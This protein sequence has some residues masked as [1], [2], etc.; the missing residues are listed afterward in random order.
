MAVLYVVYLLVN[1][2]FSRV[3]PGRNIVVLERRYVDRNSSIVL[4]RLMNDYYF[5]LITQGG[6]TVIKKLDEVEAGKLDVQDQFKKVFFKKLGKKSDE[7]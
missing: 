3:L 4:V 6:G 5:I 2:R 7:G 1:R